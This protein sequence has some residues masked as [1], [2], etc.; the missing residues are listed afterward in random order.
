MSYLK[1][2]LK[3]S[4]IS[5][6]MERYKEQVGI[7]HARPQK[8][9]GSDGVLL[10]QIDDSIPQYFEPD[11]SGSHTL[12]GALGAKCMVRFFNQRRGIDE[13][14]E[15]IL[16][17]PLEESMQRID[18]E[19]SEEEVYDFERFPHV[20]PEKVHLSALPEVILED[21][22]L[23]R[24]IRELKEYLYHT[25]ALTLWRCR[26]LKMESKIEE[27]ESDFL[28][29]VEDVLQEKKEAEIEK[30]KERYG[31][32][33]KVLLDRLQRAKE[34]AEK[35]SADSMN[36]LIETGISVLGA[37]FGKTSITKVGRA[38]NQGSKIFK[39]RGEMS[40][41]NAR[42]EALQDDLAALEEELEEKVDVIDNKYHI[43]NYE[44][45]LFKIKPRK[46]DIDVENCALVW[47]VS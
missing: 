33:E 6:L 22:G 23:R 17:L 1:G 38:V 14:R 4:E 13:E 44:I 18:W 12:F 11:V 30:L 2:P 7:K 15:K 40:R 39:E 42:V 8:R 32:K 31:K 27:S 20:A 10:Q 24:S 21:R 43:E 46:T 29:R 36:S 34:R 3:K 37:L 45:E 26:S 5:Q 9:V 35:E 47:R 25:E 19:M 28:V 41:A 16:Y